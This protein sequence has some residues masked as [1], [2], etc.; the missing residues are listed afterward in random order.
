MN[1]GH[2]F[3]LP[4]DII[5]YIAKML[6]PF[7]YA[8]IRFVCK[9]FGKAITGSTIRGID[10]FT[11]LDIDRR[12]LCDL[13]YSLITFC[14][15]RGIVV[16]TKNAYALIDT[17][18]SRDDHIELESLT[19]RCYIHNSDATLPISHVRIVQRIIASN[20]PTILLAMRSF[21]G[22][23]L[24]DRHIYF[25]T[26]VC[27]GVST[28]IMKILMTSGVFHLCNIKGTCDSIYMG[29]GGDRFCGSDGQ[30]YPLMSNVS[31]SFTN[32][33]TYPAKV[34]DI[35]TYLRTTWK[36]PD[37]VWEKFMIALLHK[38]QYDMLDRIAHGLNMMPPSI[39]STLSTTQYT[40]K[41][42]AENAAL[43]AR[44]YDI[45]G[46]SKVVRKRQKKNHD[47]DYLP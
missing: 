33:E 26:A 23:P 29:I 22:G 4:D 14:N 43:H 12:L 34:I 35:I 44:F 2:I 8:R 47:P 36:V 5:R 17:F 39:C 32:D 41:T 30:R 6:D 20:R 24:I 40:H 31:S 9:R 10:H 11:R 18:I 45:C 15:Y 21:I 3:C 1:E 27:T 28:K 46:H 37:I 7:N 19:L 42:E 16:S 38:N 13:Y 25:W